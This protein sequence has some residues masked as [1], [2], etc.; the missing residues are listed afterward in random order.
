LSDVE[1]LAQRYRAVGT[2]AVFSALEGVGAPTR[3][4]ALEIRPIDRGQTVTAQRYFVQGVG[5]TG[6]KG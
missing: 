2:A 5:M 4:I 6:L 3:L 1:T